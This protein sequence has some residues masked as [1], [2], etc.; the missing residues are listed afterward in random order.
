M[1]LSTPNPY[2]VIEGKEAIL[3]CA[4]TDANP[5]TSIIWRWFNTQNPS[6]VLY[7]KPKYI[8]PN[9]TRKMSGFYNC[10]ANNSVGTSEAVT[11]HLDILCKYWL[12]ILLHSSIYFISEEHD[13]LM[14]CKRGLHYYTPAP[15]ES[16]E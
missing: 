12:I 10:T 4:V 15:I 8:I 2:I 16:A 11:V 3:E 13:T 14:G 1:T 6:K 7:S 5:N 9:I